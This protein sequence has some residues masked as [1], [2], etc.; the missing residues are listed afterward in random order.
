MGRRL[1][2]TLAMLVVGTALLVASGLARPAGGAS[3]AGE[4]AKGGTLRL[5]SFA[6]VGRR[7]GAGVPSTSWPVEVRDVREALQQPG[8]GGSRGDEGRSRRS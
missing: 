7:P 1:G 3:A 6:D 4:A 5:A 2:L 8:R